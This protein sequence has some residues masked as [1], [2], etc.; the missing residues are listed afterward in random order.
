M[1]AAGRDG[2]DLARVE[3]VLV[4][5]E[6]G[7]EGSGFDGE[8]FGL[9]FV[10]V[11]GW[12]VDRGAGA[13]GAAEEGFGGGGSGGGGG[14]GGGEEGGVGCGVFGGVGVEVGA[15]GAGRGMGEEGEH[16]G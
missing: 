1:V 11:V 16:G 9:V 14:G 2:A 8:V 7:E 3:G 15:G 4:A 6:H 5:V 12:V 10:P 13:L